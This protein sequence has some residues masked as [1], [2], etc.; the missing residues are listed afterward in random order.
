MRK[1]LI[2]FV[3][4]LFFLDSFSQKAPPVIEWQ[5][6]LGGSRIDRAYTIMQLPT[7]ITVSWWLENPIL[8]MAM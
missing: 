2:A 3:L 5:K 8:T 4:C 1:L 6:S 7:L